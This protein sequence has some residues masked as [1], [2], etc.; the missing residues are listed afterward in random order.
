LLAIALN[1]MVEIAQ[2]RQER[3]KIIGH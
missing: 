2:V 3:W 1:H